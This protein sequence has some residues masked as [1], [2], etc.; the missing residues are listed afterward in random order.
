LGRPWPVQIFGEVQWTWFSRSLS[1]AMF[2]FLDTSACPLLPSSGSRLCQFPTF[3][4]TMKGVRL[5]PFHPG[6]LRFLGDW[7]LFREMLLRSPGRR[8]SADSRAWPVRVGGDHSR[9]AGGKRLGALP[10]FR[11]ILESA[12]RA[13]DSGGSWQPRPSGRPDTAFRKANGVGI[14]IDISFR[15]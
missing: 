14:R 10:G 12:P 8:I 11:R 7:Y 9:K 1:T 13:R 4:G 5:L 6:R 3:I 15:S 2:P